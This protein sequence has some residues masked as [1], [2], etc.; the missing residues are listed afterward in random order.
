MNCPHCGR[1]ITRVLVEDRSRRAAQAGAA[2]RGDSKRRNVDY[3]ELG[4]R[5]AASRK[6]KAS[7]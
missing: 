7:E 1:N 5:G 3:A 6:A 2:G 4:R